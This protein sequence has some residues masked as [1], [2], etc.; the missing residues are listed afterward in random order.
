MNSG[1]IISFKKFTKRRSFIMINK[2][3]TTFM[4]HVYFSINF[5]TMTHLDEWT[6]AELRHYKTSQ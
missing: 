4:Q 1:G 2:S 3:Q 6:V 5:S